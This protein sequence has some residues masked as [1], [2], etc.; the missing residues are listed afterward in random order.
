MDSFLKTVDQEHKD[1]FAK[2]AI[3]SGI[4]G[5]HLGKKA[6]KNAINELSNFEKQG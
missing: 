6:N 5:S 3:L 2:I 1:V 4:N